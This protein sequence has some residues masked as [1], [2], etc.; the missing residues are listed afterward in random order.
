MQKDDLEEINEEYDSLKSKNNELMEEVKRLKEFINSCNVP[1]ENLR[2]KMPSNPKY[3]DKSND[4]MYENL[5]KNIGKILVNNGE[6]NNFVMNTSYKMTHDLLN[7]HKKEIFSSF[8]GGARAGGGAVMP[9]KSFIVGERGME[10]FQPSVRGNI[11]R[12]NSFSNNLKHKNYNSSFK[13]NDKQILNRILG[14]F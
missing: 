12:N 1:L 7:T 10:V 13:A 14:E 3:Q 5:G 9:G 8:F 6:N 4:N 2:K 11:K